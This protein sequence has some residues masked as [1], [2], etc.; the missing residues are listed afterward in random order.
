MSDESRGCS[1]DMNPQRILGNLESKQTKWKAA[2]GR[3]SAAAGSLM[4]SR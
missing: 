4:I 3:T 2:M 1:E